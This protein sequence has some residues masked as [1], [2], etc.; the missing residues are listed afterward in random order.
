MIS[1][2]HCF[3]KDNET[4]RKHELKDSSLYK[5][6]VG[7]HYRNINALDDKFAEVKNVSKIM[8]FKKKHVKYC[9]ILDLFT[10]N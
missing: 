2:A 8:K 9:K 1:A 3:V 7:K 6:A 5:I 10:F 4:E